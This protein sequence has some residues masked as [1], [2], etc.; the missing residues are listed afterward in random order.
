MK[1][2]FVLFAVLA[3]TACTVALAQETD[4]TVIELANG[5]ILKT[6]NNRAISK[7]QSN[8]YDAI[9][10]YRGFVDLGYIID[11]RTY[12]GYNGFDITTSHGYQFNPYIFL[13]GGLGMQLYKVSSNNKYLATIPAFVDFRTNFI[14]LHKYSS[15]R[16]IPF[17]GLKIGYTTGVFEGETG[18]L[19]SYIVPSL[20]VKAMLTSSV[21]LNL[22]IGYTLQL[23]VDEYGYEVI[24]TLGG[25]TIKAGIEF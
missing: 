13:G 3:F 4:E 18:T 2:L 10:G 12:D 19:G 22:S 20:G 5:S 7:A 11:L 16:I 8:S 14:K 24:E 15:N 17:A 21:A 23:V 1:R 9:I 25:I 6:G